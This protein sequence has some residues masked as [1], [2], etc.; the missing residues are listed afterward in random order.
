MHF[1]IIVLY[2]SASILGEVRKCRTKR[3]PYYQVS[4]KRVE[5]ESDPDSLE[6]NA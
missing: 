4:P 6:E 3:D 2:I 5:S 1:F